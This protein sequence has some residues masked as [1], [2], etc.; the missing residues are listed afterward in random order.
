[1]CGANRVLRPALLRT[2][3]GGDG[4]AQGG[5]RPGR[6]ATASRLAPGLATTAAEANR[7]C[8]RL[9]ALAGQEG[10]APR[11]S[12]SGEESIIKTENP[13]CQSVFAADSVSPEPFGVGII[14]F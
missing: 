10:P 12:G 6:T 1:M 2:K 13:R 7:V 14:E 3:V 8:R 11:F 5:A 4:S 9:A